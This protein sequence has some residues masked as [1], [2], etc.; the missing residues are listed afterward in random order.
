MWKR[1]FRDEIWSRLDQKWD[2]IIVGGGITGAGILGEAT[3]HGKRPS[4]LKPTISHRA[5]QAD[6]PNWC[7]VAFAI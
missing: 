6:R 3:R 4:L 7:T 5:H 2:L 1:G